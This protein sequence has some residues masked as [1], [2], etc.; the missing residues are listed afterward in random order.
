MQNQSRLGHTRFPALGGGHVYLL[1]VLIGSLCC[2]RLLTFVVIGHCKVLVLV[3]R[4]STVCIFSKVQ[5][6]VAMSL[7]SLRIDR[8][9]DYG[10]Q[11]KEQGGQV[12]VLKH[13]KRLYSAVKPLLDKRNKQRFQEGYLTYPYL[14]PAWIPNS[15][16]T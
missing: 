8:L 6:G 10:T 5:A 9:F 11:L 12:I 3:L 14:S 4:H 7:G 16:C 15:I 1:R 13:Y 2:L